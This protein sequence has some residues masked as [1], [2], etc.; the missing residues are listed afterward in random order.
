MGNEGYN[1]L[2]LTMDRQA[3][4]A[5]ATPVAHPVAQVVQRI[6]S[7]THALDANSTPPVALALPSWATELCT[8]DPLEWAQTAVRHLPEMLNCTSAVCYLFTPGASALR[9]VA[10]ST[11]D[12]AAAEVPLEQALDPRV[13]A[14]FQRRMQRLPSVAAC[15][16]QG[17]TVPAHLTTIPDSNW[18]IEP[19][20]YEGEVLGLLEF[21]GGTAIGETPAGLT[22]FLARTLA[23][24]LQY[25]AARND[26]RHDALTGLYNYRWMSE[27][28]ER[29]IHRTERQGGALALLMLD[30]DDL[31][32]VNDRHGHAAGDALLKNLAQKLLAV[33]R[34]EDASARVGGDEFVVLLP[35]TPVG[36]TEQILARLR[37]TLCGQTL[38]FNSI[39]IRWSVAIGWAQWRAG[40]NGAQLIHEADQ[41][42]YAMKHAGSTR[43]TTAPD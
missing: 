17:V 35:N 3:A 39:E 12:S 38:L 27:S 30:V 13:A 6:A 8:L 4:G 42:L 26:A 23:N 33:L 11:T 5:D 2:T 34:V 22:R 36:L 18:L 32:W 15:R 24:A 29:E 1:N 10:G 25:C 16:A 9:A 43:R 20:L 37:R 41:A 14:L 7:A 28:L 21:S 40:Q 19:L 31:K